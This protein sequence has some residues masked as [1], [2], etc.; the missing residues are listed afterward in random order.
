MNWQTMQR[1]KLGEKIKFPLFLNIKPFITSSFEESSQGKATKPS[2]V[3]MRNRS[4]KAAEDDVKNREG[5]ECSKCSFTN[6][7]DDTS[8]G[9]CEVYDD[10]VEEGMEYEL[11]SMMIHT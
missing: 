7:H 5:W 2:A 4:D 11:F 9:F 8:C 3:L 1:K 6:S 10:A